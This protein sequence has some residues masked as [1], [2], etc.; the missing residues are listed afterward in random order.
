[1]TTEERRALEARCLQAVMHKLDAAAKQ[2]GPRSRMKQMILDYGVVEGVRQIMTHEDTSG[3]NDLYL[4]NLLDHS[5]EATIVES[6]D[7]RKLFE[8][9]EISKM[10]EYL[11]AAGYTPRPP[12]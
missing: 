5:V 3:W 2:I 9:E 12:Q 6:C 11:L 8:P 4:A 1:L 7:F 10:E